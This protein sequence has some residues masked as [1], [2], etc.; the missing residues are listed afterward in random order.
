MIVDTEGCFNNS[1][2]FFFFPFFFFIRSIFRD[3]S[4][5]DVDEKVKGCYTCSFFQLDKGPGDEMICW[6]REWERKEESETT[7]H[8]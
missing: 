2:F 6:T 4:G 1:P 5:G 7:D 3:R 8:V